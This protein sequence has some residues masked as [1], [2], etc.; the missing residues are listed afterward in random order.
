MDRGIIGRFGGNEI[1]SVYA[2]KNF[3]IG[4]LIFNNFEVFVPETPRLQFPF[5]LSSTLFYGIDYEF[6]TINE[7]FVVKIK[8]AQ[9]LEREFKIRELR[10]QLYPQIDEILIQDV[11]IFLHDCFI[12]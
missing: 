3:K 2:I 11:D 5:L 1:G 12:F 6:D 9:N 10:G 7:K 4:D 8:D